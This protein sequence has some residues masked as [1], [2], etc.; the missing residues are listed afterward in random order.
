MKKTAR[1]ERRGKNERY[2]K[3]K[4]IFF[5]IGEEKTKS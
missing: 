2:N 4:K 5:G 3:I 1:T